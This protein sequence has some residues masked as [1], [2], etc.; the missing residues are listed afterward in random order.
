MEKYKGFIIGRT[1][2]WF[3]EK[4]WKD[5]RSFQNFISKDQAKRW[6]DSW[7]LNQ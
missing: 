3:D 7:V 1:C 6:I 5:C 4:G 2:I